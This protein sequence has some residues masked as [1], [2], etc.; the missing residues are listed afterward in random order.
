MHCSITVFLR[1]NPKSEGRL[2]VKKSAENSLLCGE[3]KDYE[4]MNNASALQWF[5]PEEAGK[6]TCWHGYPINY[7]INLILCKDTSHF[8]PDLSS[9]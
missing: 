4:N 2:V 9:L 5:Q 6:L 3:R 7:Y 8:I 1:V